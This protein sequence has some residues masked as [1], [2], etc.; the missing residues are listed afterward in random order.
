[1]R[2]RDRAGC[3]VLDVYRAAGALLHPIEREGIMKKLIAASLFVISFAVLSVSNNA[4][5]QS[6]TPSPDP[7]L[8][9]RGL[10]SN[11]SCQ[12]DSPRIELRQPQP[13]FQLGVCNITC[14]SCVIGSPCPRDPETGHSQTCVAN[15]P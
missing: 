15:C 8:S 11:A 2:F 13:P 6:N 10:S 1:V 5:S 12:L 7:E 14:E 9:G 4:S 3:R